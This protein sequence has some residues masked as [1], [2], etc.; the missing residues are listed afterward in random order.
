M[1][2]PGQPFI[3]DLAALMRDLGELEGAHRDEIRRELWAHL[4]DAAAERGAAAQDPTTQRL[5]IAELGGLQ[6]MAADFQNAYAPHMRMQRLGW[7]VSLLGAVMLVVLALW[8]VVAVF[9]MDR[10]HSQGGA[11]A[12]GQR[13]ETG[14]LIWTTELRPADPAPAFMRLLAVGGVGLSGM[15]MAYGIVQQLRGR[16]AGWLLRISPWTATALILGTLPFSG[17]QVLLLVAGMLPLLVG[18]AIRRAPPLGQGPQGVQ[19]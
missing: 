4:E 17:P 11:V 12:V 16:S 8:Y 10:V 6:T 19:V 3:D 18:A 5:I 15:V 14:E 13:T 1:P 2:D 7:R 9:P